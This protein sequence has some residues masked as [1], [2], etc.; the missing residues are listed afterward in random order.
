V[1]LLPL[2][3]SVAENLNELGWRD[4]ILYTSSRL[5]EAMSGSRCRLVKYYLVA[6]PVASQPLVSVAPGQDFRIERVGSQ[7]AL[8]PQ[9][10]RPPEV[11][12]KRYATGAI[13]FAASKQGRLAGFIWLKHDCYEED[14]VRCVYLPMP[15]DQAVWDFDV[16]IDPAFRLSRV[17]LRLWDAAYA[18]LREQN[19]RWTLSRISGFNV[20]SLASHERLGAVRLGGATYLCIGAWQLSFSSFRP[21]LH[22]SRNASDAPRLSLRAPEQESVPRCGP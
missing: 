12:A 3:R 8:T 18:Y 5:L 6:Q 7:H 1:K 9:F 15:A 22:L 21:A 2:A 14:E 4:G 10:P 13:C 20:N 16:Y 19:I 11:I 17:F